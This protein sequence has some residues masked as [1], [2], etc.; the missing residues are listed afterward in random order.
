MFNGASNFN[1]DLSAWDVSSVTV[2]NG[3][4]LGAS[5][6]N[7]DIST[8]DV[9]SVTNMGSMFNGASNFNRDVS[10]WDVSSVTNMN[11]MFLDASNFNGEISAWDV[12]SATSMNSVF[13]NASNFNGDVSAWDVSSVTNMGRMF[14]GTNMSL[15]NYDALLNGW[16]ALPSLQSNVVFWGRAQGW[17]EGET[18]IDI[19]MGP[20]NNWQ[21]SSGDNRDVTCTLSTNNFDLDSN[22]RIF[23]D[24]QGDF[25][26]VGLEKGLV[27]VCIYNL[28]AEQIFE[29]TFEGKEF[30]DIKFP[31]MKTGIYIIQLKTETGRLNKKLI[32]Q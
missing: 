3:L 29:T 13:L 14:E 6:F 17:C 15:E 12:S 1:G 7:G 8:W 9:Y 27:K 26:I 21:F 19:L 16:A 25:R 10:A 11:N 5:N 4:F 2:M 23:T 32:I 30:N 28:L 20:P 22:I 24:S 18:G 31:N